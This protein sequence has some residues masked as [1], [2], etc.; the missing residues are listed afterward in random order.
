MI[1]LG[2]LG[3]WEDPRGLDDET[4][5]KLTGE[6]LEERDGE[7]CWPE[8]FG[9]A[10]LRK[11][12]T[13]M[14][15]YAVAGQ[16]QQRPAPREGAIIRAED[17][18]DWPPFE[19]RE[20]LELNPGEGGVIKAEL[21]LCDYVV[22]C[23]DTAYKEGQTNDFNA[24]T[25]WGAWRS[26]SYS[27]ITPH[28]HPILVDQI[29]GAMRIPNDTHTK[30]ILMYAWQ[31]RV[32]LHGPPEDRPE[33]LT[34][35]EWK[36]PR[37]RERRQKNWGLVEWTND[38]CRRF[39]VSTLLIEDKTRGNDVR[40]ELFRLNQKMPYDVIMMD[41]QGSDKIMRANALAHLWSNGLIYAPLVY[42][43]GEWGYPRWCET[44]I[45]QFT[46][47]PR[48]T[49]DDIVD[50]GLYAIKH[51]RDNGI[52][53][54]TEEADDNFVEDAVRAIGQRKRTARLYDT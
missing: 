3:V 25:V 19:V 15:D 51:F 34:D 26:S 13:D 43:N 35:A 20:Q 24:I 48:G 42:A 21:P 50:T 37:W 44:A 6:A 4:G 33:G 23:L 41:P 1:D 2:S 49:H 8:R 36:S 46:I 47:F 29:G 54:R 31:R 27:T 52:L 16:L 22:A 28:Y 18:C 11:L 17:W 7:I 10:A 40:A 32:P 39:H 53:F 38:I 12:K 9:P 30:V 45:D 5:E 14:D